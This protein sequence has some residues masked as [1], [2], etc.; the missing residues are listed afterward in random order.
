VLNDVQRKER[1]KKANQ[2]AEKKRQKTAASGVGDFEKH[3][4]GI[5]QKM[6]KLMGYKPG[7]GLGRNKQVIL[8][9]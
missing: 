4:K 2:V 9:I 8:C 7:E 5:G 1:E 6:M 3:T